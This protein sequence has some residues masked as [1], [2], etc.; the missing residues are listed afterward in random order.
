MLKDI[1]TR[2]DLAV[3]S[4]LDHVPINVS[5][6]L[7]LFDAHIDAQV[8]VTCVGISTL[9]PIRPHAADELLRYI[10]GHAMH[11]GKI[12]E[13]LHRGDVDAAH[14]AWSHICED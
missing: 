6:D 12:E 4:A 1:S 9:P 5:L 2:W 13:A 11:R 8:P 10:H 14:A 3:D 7:T